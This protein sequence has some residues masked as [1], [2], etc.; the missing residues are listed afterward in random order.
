M[1]FGI[2]DRSNI[3][4]R[5]ESAPVDLIETFTEIPEVI[6]APMLKK[7]KNKLKKRTAKQ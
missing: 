4:A 1:R 2:S 3:L 5:R 6:E 7:V